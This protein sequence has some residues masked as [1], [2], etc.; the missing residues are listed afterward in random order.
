[1]IF[2]EEIE[3]H[4]DLPKDKHETIEW[5]RDFD[6]ALISLMTPIEPEVIKKCPHLKYI[7]M[8]GT[9]LHRVAVEEARAKDI[10]VTNVEDYCDWETAEFV[11]A[12]II[13]ITRK[14][15]KVHWKKRPTTLEG[16]KLAIVGMGKVGHKLAEM[17]LGLKMNVSYYSRTRHPEEGAMG[18]HYKALPKLLEESEIISVHTPP[19]LEIL[20]KEAFA[21]MGDGKI[22]V[23]TCIG[24]TMDKE[25]FL[26]WIRH[27][28]NVAIFDKISSRPFDGLDQYKNV[29]SYRESAFEC[30]EATNNLS[31]KFIQN[32][33]SFLKK[34]DYFTNG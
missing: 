21:N 24:E 8:Y 12:Q 33:E 11:I 9:S 22:L 25:G 2:A 29:I 16:K 27:P 4:D 10:V 31:E 1:M 32:I 15:G 17:A 19:H 26:G 28:G 7:G 30:A 3:V 5:L 20:D 6:A 23:N 13:Q 34:I 14:L 18:V